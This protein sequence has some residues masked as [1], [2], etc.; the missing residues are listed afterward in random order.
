MDSEK[1]RQIIADH[2]LWLAGNGGAKV[3][4]R[5]ADL[6]NA[7][8]R[9]ADLGGAD[10]RRA[11]L[12]RADL[13]GVNLGDADL[14]DANL[15]GA[16]LRGANLDAPICRMDFGGWS[17]C[18]CADETSIGCQT[19]PNADWLRWTPD[20]VAE[21]AAGAKDWWQIHGVAVKAAIYCVMGKAAKNA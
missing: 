6:R 13:G 1:L 8:L 12:R 4:L 10:L 20:D 9:N 11:D 16:N 15:G 2:A 5:G 21:F 3:D 19:H 7:N 14:R 18:I 17:I